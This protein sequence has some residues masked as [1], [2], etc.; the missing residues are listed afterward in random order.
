[1][2]GVSGERQDISKRGFITGPRRTDRRLT[3]RTVNS[4]P[5]KPLQRLQVTV[6][7]YRTCRFYVCIGFGLRFL[8]H[9]PARVVP[10]WTRLLQVVGSSVSADSELKQASGLFPT[11]NSPS[12]TTHPRGVGRKSKVHP[13]RLGFSL[14]FK[15]CFEGS[16]YVTE[17]TEELR[18][19]LIE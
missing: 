4:G 16:R 8:Y 12:R 5:L 9:C 19:T 15:F 1:M 10:A 11:Q 2:S 17:V 3:V 7:G 13:L 14:D 18:T 6:K